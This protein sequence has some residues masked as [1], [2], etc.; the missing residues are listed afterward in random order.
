VYF[1][2]RKV[3]SIKCDCRQKGWQWEEDTLINKVGLTPATDSDHQM[4]VFAMTFRCPTDQE[5]TAIGSA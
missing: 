3:L 2:H 5:Y 1:I 4:T